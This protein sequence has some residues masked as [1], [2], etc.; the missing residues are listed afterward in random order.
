MKRPPFGTNL[1]KAQNLDYLPM[2][3]GYGF[4][5]QR[6]PAP[7]SNSSADGP[8]TRRLSPDDRAEP[9]GR[10][11]SGVGAFRSGQS[12]RFA[13]TVISAY[14]GFVSSMAN[15]NLKSVKL[16]AMCGLSRFGSR[17]VFKRKP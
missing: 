3:F 7:I 14:D 15:T 12:V 9:A 10:V 4:H 2:P 11:A 1:D 17:D 13:R 16:R 6:F 5:A 8:W